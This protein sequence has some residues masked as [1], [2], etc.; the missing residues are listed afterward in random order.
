MRA[1]LLGLAAC[2]LLAC[3]GKVVLDAAGADGGGTTTGG[4]GGSA[5]G[6]SCAQL[7]AALDA[8]IEAARACDPAAPTDPCMMAVADFCG[9]PHVV[10]MQG[11][12]AAEVEAALQA[13]HAAGCSQPCPGGCPAMNPMFAMCVGGYCEIPG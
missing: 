2:T 6:G 5:D 8:A 7:F 9:C 10:S 3:G 13:V 4:Q 12:G 1:L 11:N